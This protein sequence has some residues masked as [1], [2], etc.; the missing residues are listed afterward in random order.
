[1]KPIDE[2]VRQMMA[3]AGRVRAGDPG[4]ATDVIQRALRQDSADGR[5]L[6]PV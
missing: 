6:P 5:A 3:S 2:F 1:M 4:A